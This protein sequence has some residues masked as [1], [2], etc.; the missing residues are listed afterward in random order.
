MRENKRFYWLKLN[1]DFF[2]DDTIRWIEEQENGEK[3]VLFYLKL[4]LR[5]LKDE[6]RLIRY[7]GEVLVPYDIKALSKLTNTDKDTVAV[8][9]DLF[10]QIGL[11]EK[12]EIGDIY[13]KQINEMIGSE[14]ES[15]KKMRRLRA[16]E[17][18]LIPSVA[19]DGSQCDY[20]V[21][22]CDSD[23]MKCD[24]D[25]EIDI[26]IDKD[27]DK[28]KEEKKNPPPFEEII[29]YFN[30]VVGRNLNHTSE[31]HR[32]PIRARWNEGYVLDDF[33]RV[34]D[35]KAKEWMGTHMES[36]LKPSTLFALKH[37]DNYLN[38]PMP[39]TNQ[40]RNLAILQSYVE[41]MDCELPGGEDDES[42]S[43]RSDGIPF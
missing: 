31:G 22:E 8:A 18:A 29:S 33:K 10:Q 26:E 39:M 13:M 28:E 15:A 20:E 41:K 17:K 11:I 16:R 35:V 43:D 19:D 24:T 42:R 6:G 12:R 37:F 32:K 2:E 4:C 21:I 27:I 14:T 5:S 25:I 36:N 38:Q 30:S 40:E 9:L 34:I 7:V 1:E 3:Y 23:V